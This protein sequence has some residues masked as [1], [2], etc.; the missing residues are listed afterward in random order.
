MGVWFINDNTSSGVISHWIAVLVKLSNCP[1]WMDQRWYQY[2]HLR[3]SWA[4]HPIHPAATAE[5]ASILR[6]FAVSVDNAGQKTQSFPSRSVPACH[7]CRTSFRHGLAGRP[8][9]AGG[10]ITD[11][12]LAPAII[13]Q[14][15]VAVAV[16]TYNRSPRT[17][18]RL[19]P[20]GLL[21]LPS[22]CYMGSGGSGAARLLCAIYI[23]LH[24]AHACV[25]AVL[26]Q[27]P[28]QSGIQERINWCLQLPGWHVG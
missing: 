3:A 28:N 17:T 8:G 12:M 10:S 22:R 7:H 26:V 6:R 21:L 2:H 20:V 14:P 18:V 13:C 16:S 15:A 11:Q 4:D 5:A 1:R 9:P 25:I 27:D 23:T 24:V 19:R